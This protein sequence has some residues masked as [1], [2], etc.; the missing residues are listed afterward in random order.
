MMAKMAR[1]DALEIDC[2]LLDHTIDSSAENLKLHLKL[3]SIILR[4]I[5]YLK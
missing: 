4:W 1:N 3:A 5:Q 2:Q